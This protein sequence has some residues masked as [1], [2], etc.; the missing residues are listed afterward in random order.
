MTDYIKKG[1]KTGRIITAVIA[2]F[3]LIIFILILT[4]L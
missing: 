2:G 3:F 1:I 4:T